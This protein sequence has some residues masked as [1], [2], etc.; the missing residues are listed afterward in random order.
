MFFPTKAVKGSLHFCFLLFA[1]K[2]KN[3]DEHAAL[4]SVKFR[5]TTRARDVKFDASI[6]LENK[7]RKRKSQAVIDYSIIRL[8]IISC[9]LLQFLFLSFPPM[10]LANN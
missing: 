6:L 2:I 7:P 5:L 10:L 1:M 9:R 8:P 4:L 3:I